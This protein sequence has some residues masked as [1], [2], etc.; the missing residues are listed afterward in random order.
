MSSQ[1]TGTTSSG[2]IPPLAPV[3]S[4][5]L[6]SHSQS[7]LGGGNNQPSVTRKTLQDTIK[8]IEAQITLLEQT[9]NVTSRQQDDLA[10]LRELHTRALAEQEKLK[11]SKQQQHLQQQLQQQQQQQHL[12]QQLHQ[13]PATPT[14]VPVRTGTPPSA[15]LNSTN[16][17]SQSVNVT[18][19]PI[20]SV[21]TPAISKPSS[22]MASGSSMATG[23]HS[24][25]DPSQILDRKRIQDLV[26][27]VDPN[28]QLDEDVEEML[29]Q[30]A[31][32]F[33]ENIV[34]SGC[35]LAKHRK[36]NTL[37]TK[38]ILLHLERNWNMMIPGFSTEDNRQYKRPASTEAHK[39]RMALI[40]K[41]LKK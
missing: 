12:Q 20:Q 34:T 9:P 5:S 30:I 22:S 14:T 13:Q 16:G 6:M 19:A 15:S 2:A 36:S 27:E 29:L 8:E 18:P 23:A 4:S 37:E 3:S 35:Q 28:T 26:K 31:D 40:R 33:I 24:S 25:I 32:D 38:D 11:S 10:K 1:Q 7:Q 17:T 39:Q 21:P 41:T